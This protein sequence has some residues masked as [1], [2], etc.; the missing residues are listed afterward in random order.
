MSPSLPNAYATDVGL[1]NLISLGKYRLRLFA[2]SNSENLR[3][4]KSAVPMIKSVVMPVLY[5][6]ISIVF[7]NRSKAKMLRIDARRVIAG[8]HNNHPF[9]NFADKQ[10]VDVSMSLRSFPVS[11]S[12]GSDNSIS[13]CGV[14]ASPEPAG[15]SFAHPILYG[16]WSKD[17][18]V[19]CKPS[20]AAFRHIAQLAQIAAECWLLAKHAFL[21]ML[22]HGCARGNGPVMTIP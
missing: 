18:F 17:S 9:G 5:S 3:H 21:L 15:R 13:V 22:F 11:A 1:I 10:S 16:N 6:C 7:S 2:F 4:G 12:S 20:C 8:V 14:V 19:S